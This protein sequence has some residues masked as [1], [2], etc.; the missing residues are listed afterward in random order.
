MFKE[1]ARF[2]AAP[3]DPDPLSEYRRKRSPGATPEPAGGPGAEGGPAAVGRPARFVVQ[4]HAARR[5][6]WDLRLEMNGV[7]RSWAVPRGPSLDPAERRLAVETE[8]HPMEYADFEGVIPDGNYGAGAMIVWDRGAWVPKL[9]PDEGM[10]TGKQLFDLQGYKLRGEWTLVRTKKPGESEPSR[11]WLLIKKPDAHA[12]GEDAEAMGAESVLSG[13]TVDELASGGERAARL[14][15]ELDELGAPRRAVPLAGVRP[16]LAETA[17]EPFSR[18]GWVFEL[19]YDGYRL[20]AA[21]GDAAGETGPHGVQGVRMVYRSGRDATAA[22]PDL[23]RALA[24]LPFDSLVLDGEVAVLDDEGRPSFQRLQRRAL[25]SRRPDVERAAVDLPAVFFVFDLLAFEG[26]DLRGLPLVERKRL[27]ADALPAAGP[28]RYADHVEE[29]GAELYEAV[30]ARG[31]EGLLAKKADSPYRGGR[32]PAWLKV[33]ADRTAELAVVGTT[34]P[35][36]SRGGFGALHLAWRAGARWVYA[37]RVG[38]GFTEADLVEI[39]ARLEPTLREP[40]GEPPPDL[41]PAPGGEIPRGEEHAWVEP[42][43]VVEVRYKEVT[44]VGQL[45][46]PVFLRLREDRRPEDCVL[47]GGAVGEHPEEPDEAEPEEMAEGSVEGES[48]EGS[49]GG[50]APAARRAPAAARPR[51]RLTNLDKVFWPDEGYTKGD[52]IA[53]YRAVAPAILPFLRDRPVV[54]DR[55]PDGVGGKSFFQKNAADFTPAWVRLEEIHGDDPDD[56]PTR[57]FVADDE[58]TLLY[59]ANLG[60]VPLHVVSSRVGSLERPDWAI[61]DL[62]AKDAPFSAAVEVARAIHR[63]C[64][65]IELPSFVKTSGATGLHVLVPTGRQMTHDQAKQLAELIARVVA[66]ELP[67]I[68]SVA[69]LPGA[70]KGKVYLDYLQNGWGKLLVSPYCVRP[71]PGAPVSAPLRWS[72]LGPKLSPKKFTIE[73]MPRRLARQKRDPMA[74]LLTARPDLVSALARLAGKV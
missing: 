46:Q 64:D 38:S 43:L 8:P 68:A 28:V 45:R 2:R 11:E 69:R 6:H 25:L 62:D 24:A 13:L 36:G 34:A 56:P 20:L 57:Y 53:Y 4:Q 9:D 22:F 71:L 30:R 63:L 66:A 54:L 35:E 61:V 58:E 14:H 40:P 49:R 23:A 29:R 59:L 73:S 18:P 33:R 67:E 44:E 21:T 15:A 74:P 32:S 42:S 37:G 47:E 50:E 1:F 27:L 3:P 60:T 19:K 65:E 10:E 51:L 39:A 72:E 26:R 16:M 7:L 41:E 55:Y 48:G 52:L 17:P 5:M 70:R 31:L 12:T